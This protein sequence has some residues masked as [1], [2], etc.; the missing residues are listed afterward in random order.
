MNRCRTA[1][2]QLLHQQKPLHHS[3]PCAPHSS[4][5]QAAGVLPAGSL[6]SALVLG[7]LG[8]MPVPEG[9]APTRLSA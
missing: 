7:D 3:R 4:R 9:P 8:A 6:V 2:G 1:A 5:P